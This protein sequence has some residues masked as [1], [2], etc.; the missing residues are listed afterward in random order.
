MTVGKTQ[1]T[2]KNTVMALP[3]KFIVFL[4]TF[5]NYDKL[6]ESGET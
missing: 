6:Q 3:D 2:L 4:N 5:A 1:Q